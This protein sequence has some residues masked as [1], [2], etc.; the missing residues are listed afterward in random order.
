MDV[1]YEEPDLSIQPDFGAERAADA[2]VADFNFDP[3]TL[4]AL[5]T[6]LTPT[7]VAE[8]PRENTDSS[9]F[10]MATDLLSK[11]FYDRAFAETIRAMSRSN[12]RAEGMTAL[13][14]IFARQGLFGEAL[15][16]YHEALQLD[17][18]SR[19]AMAGQAL[20]L[21][22]LGRAVEARP[23]AERLMRDFPSDVG[24]LMLGAT[25]YADSGDTKA[26]LEALDAAHQFAPQRADIQQRI[27]DIARVVGDVDGAI[28][29]YRH[30]LRIDPDFAVVRF[31]L[32]KLL[33]A[34][35]EDHDAARELVAALDAVP[36]YA[37][38]TLALAVLKRRLGQPSESL[39]LLVDLLQ[40]DPYHFDALI[41]L[42]ETLIA[43]DRGK[44]AVHAFARVLRFDPSHVGALF[45]EGALLASQHR[46][47][48]AIHRW[49][50]VIAIASGSEYAW[51]ARRAL[52]AAAELARS[53]RSR[54]KA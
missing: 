39:D 30:A 7:A 4:D 49:D 33:E 26:A 5:F 50:R 13:G 45:H 10:A 31:Q 1:E 51:R 43:L 12:A 40:R 46:Y 27:G 19:D 9:P 38:A 20:A 52:H 48:E 21:I 23:V 53:S 54:A 6:E 47:R 17:P 44:D 41:A 29:A 2:S 36:T 32:A 42:G 24:I 25:A 11:G 18:T 15:E 37:D 22:R 28:V 3:K 8:A 34:K 14:E 16:R 35:G